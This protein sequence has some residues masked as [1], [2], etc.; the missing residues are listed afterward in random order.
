MS[1]CPMRSRLLIL[2]P[3]WDRDVQ[4][5][6]GAHLTPRS[7]QSAVPAANLHRN[8]FRAVLLGRGCGLRCRHR[9]RQFTAI[10]GLGTTPPPPRRSARLAT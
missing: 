4:S 5:S 8:P 7:A 10:E 2:I 9:C 1:P 6:V 3:A